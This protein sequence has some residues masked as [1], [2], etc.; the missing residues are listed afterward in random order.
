MAFSS[1]IGTDILETIKWNG[2][3]PMNQPFS[4]QFTLDGRKL[5]YVPGARMQNEFDYSRDGITWESYQNLSDEN[6]KK[7]INYLKT[8]LKKI[9]IN[10]DLKQSI[11][12]YIERP[13]DNNLRKIDIDDK[14]FLLISDYLIKIG[15]TRFRDLFIQ[16]R[17]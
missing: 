2:K 6:K 10:H 11:I 14:N 3:Y 12:D 13:N 4:S 8:L 1:S 17:R 15:P 9:P 16:T 7:Y 5:D